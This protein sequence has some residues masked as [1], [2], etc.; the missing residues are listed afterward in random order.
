MDRLI[1]VAMSG[2]QL[3]LGRQATVAHNL[4]NATTTGFRAEINASRAIPVQGEGGATRTFVI[5]TSVASNLTPGVIQQTGRDLD[6]AIP[7]KGWIAVQ[8]AD[9]S[10]AYTRAGSL[11]VSPNGIL[12]TR[13]GHSVMGDGGPL[14]I[15]PD[16]QITVGK[17]GTVSV[18]PSGTRPNQVAQVGRI[19]L[20][21]PEEQLLV[22]G[23]DGL[24]RL[25][26]GSTAT[27]D[28]GVRLVGAAL[29][30][31]NVNVVEEMVN[32]I[33]LARQ[34]DMQMKMLQSADANDQ[35][36]TQVMALTG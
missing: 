13:E 24:F 14:S 3:T 4:A 28:S 11:Q 7:G 8:L 18:V 23:G 2:A 16:T 27:A 10:E 17:D 19:K 15:P 21:N 25:R 33:S 30:G 22:K 34:F 5:D 32:M 12:Q 6:V 29:E 35:K 20:V 26:D 36:A 9:G 31:S 1:Y